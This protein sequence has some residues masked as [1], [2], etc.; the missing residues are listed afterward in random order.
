MSRDCTN[1]RTS[2]VTPCPLF[3]SAVLANIFAYS[4]PIFWN[5]AFILTDRVPPYVNVSAASANC[6]T[7]GRV[8]LNITGKKCFVIKSRVN[9]LGF[10]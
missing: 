6:W 7:V 8:V 10:A 5:A 4:S 1:V 9:D 2:C 3:D